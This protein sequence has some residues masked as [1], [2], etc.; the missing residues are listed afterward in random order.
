M[1]RAPSVR[2]SD[3][4]PDPESADT[5]SLQIVLDHVP[6][7]ATDVVF[8]WCDG[9]TCTEVTLDDDADATLPNSFEIPEAALGTYVVRAAVP[10]HWL[11]VAL[12]C[13][14]G[15]TVDLSL[16]E[17]TVDLAEGEQ[18]TCRFED[19]ETRVLL[20]SDEPTGTG[21]DFSY[22]LCRIGGDCYPVVL[23]D[24]DDPTLISSAWIGG[25]VP[26]TYTVS[27]DVPPGWGVIDLACGSQ[28][29]PPAAT[30]TFDL[31][32]GQQPTCRFT[33]RQSTIHLIHDTATP[34]ADDFT[35]HVCPDDGSACIDVVLDDDNDPTRPNEWTLVGAVAGVTYTVTMAT[36]GWGVPTRICTADPPAT[37]AFRWV[38]T[39]SP[40][41][42]RLCRV[43]VTQTRLTVRLDTDEAPRFATDF[44]FT[45]C[46]GAGGSGGCGAFVLDDDADPSN[47][48]SRGFDGLQAG[49]TYVVTSDPP[50]GWALVGVTCT[51][52]QADLE[53]RRVTVVVHPGEQASCT[54]RMRVTS[55]EIVQDTVPDGPTDLTFD[56]CAGPSGAHG[57]GTF[58]L[59]DD[60]NADRT[61][62]NTATFSEL[63]A[64]RAY[65]VTQRSLRGYPLTSLTCTSGVVELADGRATVVLE[66]GQQVR[67]T[68]TNRTTSLRLI[69]SADLLDGQDFRYHGCAGPGGANGCGDFVLDGA[70]G[71]AEVPGNLTFAGLDAGVLYTVTQEEVDGFG[72]TGLTCTSGVV[73]LAERL[74]TVVLQPGEQATCTFTVTATQLKV[75][76]DG[77]TEPVPF[78]GCAGPGGALG[79]GEFALAESLS[80][81]ADGRYRRLTAGVE[82]TI[83]QLPMVGLGLTALSCT[84]GQTDLATATA[85]VVLHRG[86]QVTCTFTSVVNVLT[87]VHQSSPASPQ[88]FSYTLCGP[89]P[90][91]CRP[92]SL[93]DAI[94]TSPFDDSTSFAWL[95]AGVYR[96]TQASSTAWGVT[97]IDCGGD[98]VEVWNR[99][100]TIY[101]DPG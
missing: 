100:A 10:D 5:T 80:P 83:R 34:T 74:A 20:R 51:N 72:L 61:V 77:S 90:D 27:Q 86:E 22:E 82:Y 89:T 44:A 49:E 67:C 95:E 92:F 17:A 19:R 2:W 55:L 48:S 36:P 21:T 45:G 25:L 18:V 75:V 50:S 62:A 58:V 87:V 28:V 98:P 60:G 4:R 26:G 14:T 68:F 65:T 32:L 35:Y 101:L 30:A 46:A 96:L 56:G 38:A 16:A 37:E 1:D 85:R 42:E 78:Q 29:D 84:N 9:V 12:T 11:L 97:A 81:T 43:T 6:D 23:D 64:G 13:T 3:V 63:P 33:N 93:S 70:N 76:V 73:D 53:A 99:S 7:R 59:D 52:G 40:G 15:E 54:F 39:T 41:R 91:E 31:A 79:C 47:A 69:H 66:P 8:T 24:D 71:D 94:A 57:C 88:L